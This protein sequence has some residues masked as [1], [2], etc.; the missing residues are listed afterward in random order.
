LAGLLS[1]V[2]L[3]VLAGIL[4]FGLW[5]LAPWLAELLL[6]KRDGPCR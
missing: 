4:A 2:V 1:G 5:Q 6:G 3:L